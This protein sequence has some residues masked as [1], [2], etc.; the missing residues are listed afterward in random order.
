MLERRRCFARC[1]ICSRCS[2]HSELHYCTANRDEQCS[3]AAAIDDALQMA[4]ITS[5]APAEPDAHAM[6]SS[7]LCFS[8]N[9]MTHTSEMN[10]AAQLVLAPTHAADATQR[11]RGL[12][13]TPPRATA[14]AEFRPAAPTGP[15]PRYSAACPAT[16]SS[17]AAGHS[18]RPGRS[19]RTRPRPAANLRATRLEL[20]TSL[21]RNLMSTPSLLPRRRRPVRSVKH[22]PTPFQL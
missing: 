21:L 14:V 19:R 13:L 1:T 17:P 15:R 8:A 20:R 5:D 11:N 6:W 2:L 9:E 12:K 22:P 3:T 10:A 4:V 7:R 18:P 16:R